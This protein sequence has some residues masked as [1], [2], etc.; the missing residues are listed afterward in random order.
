MDLRSASLL[1]S[2]QSDCVRAR[3]ADFHVLE[4]QQMLKVRNLTKHFRGDWIVAR[5]HDT[6]LLVLYTPQFEQVR[7]D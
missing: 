2:S 6:Q 4:I 3:I 1:Q 7:H 5:C